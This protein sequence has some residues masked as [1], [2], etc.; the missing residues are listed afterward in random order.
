MGYFSL[1]G[2]VKQKR[3]LCFCALAADTPRDG[4]KSHFNLSNGAWLLWPY[5]HAFLNK[6]TYLLERCEAEGA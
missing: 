6:N 4:F 5:Q 2:L 3:P 1:T